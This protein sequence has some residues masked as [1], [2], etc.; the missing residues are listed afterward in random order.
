MCSAC[1]ELREENAHLRRQLGLA[2]D[3]AAIYEI[4]RRFRLTRQQATLVSSLY[5]AKPR[6]LSVGVIEDL[7]RD[8]EGDGAKLVQSVVSTVRRKVGQDFVETVW[9]QG[10]RLSPIGQARVYQILHAG[11]AA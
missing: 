2:K 11:V 7:I 3:Q 10:Y 8:G 1:A 4:A 9:G 6:P 5:A